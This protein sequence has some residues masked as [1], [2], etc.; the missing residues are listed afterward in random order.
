M[1]LKQFIVTNVEPQAD[2]NAEEK[3]EEQS[4]LEDEKPKEKPKEKEKEEVKVAVAAFNPFAE[5]VSAFWFQEQVKKKPKRAPDFVPPPNPKEVVMKI[6]EISRNGLILFEFNQE[7][8]IP[9][10]VDRE[11]ESSDKNVSATND[12]SNGST[13]SS[14]SRQLVPLSMIDVS[15]DIME[16]QLLINSIVEVED[17]SFTLEVKNWTTRNL[18]IFMNFTDP[19]MISK[20]G[21]PD[22]IIFRVV[23]GQLF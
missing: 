16:I 9:P 19:L 17:V 14:E 7:M 2:P 15:R 11:P 22:E 10:F 21:N 3:V 18:G 12:T 13:N 4:K 1:V 5:K 20:G 23:N 6:K 8:L